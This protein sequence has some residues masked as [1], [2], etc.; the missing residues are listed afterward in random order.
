[1]EAGAPTAAPAGP[2][3]KTAFGCQKSLKVRRFLVPPWESSEK[4][5]VLP[6]QTEEP[7]RRMWRKE[8]TF[9]QTSCIFWHPNVVFLTG[10]GA[11]AEEARMLGQI[12]AAE[13]SGSTCGISIRGTSRGPAGGTF[14]LI[15]W[16]A[17][18]EGAAGGRRCLSP[19]FGRVRRPAVPS[20]RAPC[21]RMNR[22]IP[23]VGPRGVPRFGRLGHPGAPTHC[24]EESFLCTTIGH[25]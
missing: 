25:V 13:A 19:S 22:G 18:N 4:H 3:R 6:A 14:R 5:G 11:G 2:V 10:P 24:A 23:P 17:R 8:T 15:S 12:G 16:A 9:L 20:R 1:M 7:Y 21:P